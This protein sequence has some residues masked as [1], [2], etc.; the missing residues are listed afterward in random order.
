M[1]PG[2][3]PFPPTPVMGGGRSWVR[4]SAL[5]PILVDRAGLPG[6]QRVWHDA[7]R[8]AGTLWPSSN[9]SM[10]GSASVSDSGLRRAGGLAC[11][12]NGQQGRAL[13]ILRGLLLQ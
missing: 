2:A 10:D 7:A 1:R 3:S 11:E 12:G 8:C 13:T 5:R 6:A 4:G 9:C